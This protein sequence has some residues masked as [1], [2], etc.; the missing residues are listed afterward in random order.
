MGE[1]DHRELE[2]GPQKSGEEGE[3]KQSLTSLLLTSLP[4]SFGIKFSGN[5]NPSNWDCQ[6]KEVFIQ[7]LCCGL[8]CFVLVFCLHDVSC[9]STW[10]QSSNHHLSPT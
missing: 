8:F 10:R 5:V 6:R 3:S 9:P 4:L 2:G 1:K 7:D